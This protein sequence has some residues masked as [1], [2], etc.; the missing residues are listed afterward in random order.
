MNYTGTQL[1]KL[2]A[3]LFML[4]HANY[5]QLW[6]AQFKESG[7]MTFAR[8]QWESALAPFNSDVVKQ[9]YHQVVREHERPP[10]LPL[11]VKI[12][13]GMTA[14]IP[15]PLALPP[16]CS[17]ELARKGIEKMRAAIKRAAIK[18]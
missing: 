9:A 13:K 11:F 16:R 6:G 12:C 15:V 10:T 18:G 5:G 8:R 1:N 4:F 17:Q 7:Q 3:R 14:R 2:V